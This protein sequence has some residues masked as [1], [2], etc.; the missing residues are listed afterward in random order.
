MPARRPKKAASRRASAAAR[1]GSR[2]TAGGRKAAKSRATPRKAAKK[3]TAVRKTGAKRA[4]PKRTAARKTTAKRARKPAKR[5][6]K[7][8][9]KRTLRKA[10]PKRTAARKPAAKRAA[11][12]RKFVPA[13]AAQRAQAD[14]RELLL[15]E[16]QRARVAVMAALQGLSAG[17]AMRPMAPGKWSIHETVLHLAVRDRVR[18]DEWASLLAGRR[19]SWADVHDR[20][21]LAA[22]NDAHLAPLRALSWDEALR[23]LATTRDELMAALQAVPAEPA[24]VWSPSHPFGAVLHALPPHDRKHAEQI[25]TARVAG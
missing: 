19:A 10:A 5:V 4:A 12:P 8:A 7:A 24:D 1:S 11:R 22:I 15:F 16:I 21:A 25:K 2:R 6:A 20:A 13:F 18:L 9:P 3:R 14:A 17:T 23:L